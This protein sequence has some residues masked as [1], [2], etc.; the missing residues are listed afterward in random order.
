MAGRARAKSQDR[1]GRAGRGAQS[2]GRRGRERQGS[3]KIKVLPSRQEG[4]GETE[5]PG[6]DHFM[7]VA[8]IYRASCVTVEAAAMI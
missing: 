2:A 1:L 7:I 4:T 3:V 6:W 8:T 5:T